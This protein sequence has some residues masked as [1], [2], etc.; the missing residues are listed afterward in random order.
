MSLPRHVR[1]NSWSIRWAYWLGTGLLSP[2]FWACLASASGASS[3]KL[4]SELPCLLRGLDGFALVPCLQNYEEGFLSTTHSLLCSPASSSAYLYYL[5]RVDFDRIAHLTTAKFVLAK[6]RAV[7]LSD[8]S[9]YWTGL[10]RFPRVR[11]CCSQRRTP[12]GFYVLF[13]SLPPPGA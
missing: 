4:S 7:V 5:Y 12:A 3:P 6:S 9:P 11:D 10:Y 8:R 2:R 13:P 1:R